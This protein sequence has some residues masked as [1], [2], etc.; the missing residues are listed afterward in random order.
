MTTPGS[1]QQPQPSELLMQFAFGYVA[2]ACLHATAELGIADLLE[3]G[4]QSTEQLAKSTGVKAD[5]LYRTLRAL[6]SMGVFDEKA[7]GEFALTPISQGLLTNQPGSM[8]NM[9]RFAADP[10][11]YQMYSHML[12]VLKTGKTATEVALNQNC[13]DAF[14]KD[15]A[16][17]ARFNAAMTSFSA[18]VMPA[19]LEAYDFS[20]IKML[21]DVAGGHGFVLTSI[22]Q[23]YPE[24]KGKVMDMAHVVDGANARI[25]QMGLSERAQ[26]VAGDFFQSVP[27]GGDAYVMKH[28]IHDW[29]DERALTILKNI[30]K[31]LDGVGDGKVILLE[32][33]V[34]PGNTPHPSKM[35]DIEMMMLPGGME[36]NEQQYRELFQRAGFE[37][38]EIIPT[39]SA[40]SVLVAFAV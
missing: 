34:P 26:A 24:M 38:R 30:R 40:L 17:Q 29:D 35:L 20:G 4:P 11:H 16:E 31:S 14:A 5:F 7:A 2:G 10:W 12:E 36:R 39:K 25:Q 9:V 19:V 22:L 18:V 33:V 27:S 23:K 15:P 21:I 6:A 28:I 13:F 8:R 1:V 3:K 32:A 37:L